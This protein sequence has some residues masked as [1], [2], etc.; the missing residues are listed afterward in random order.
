[1]RDRR[2]WRRASGARRTEA[3]LA[4]D[5]RGRIHRGSGDSNPF[6]RSARG[7]TQF[8]S[9]VPAK[10]GAALDIVFKSGAAYRIPLNYIEAWF[11][12]EPV[13]SEVLNSVASGRW[14]NAVEVRAVGASVSDHGLNVDLGLSDG[15]VLTLIWETVLMACEPRF[16]LFGGETEYSRALTHLYLERHGSLRLSASRD[17]G[18]PAADED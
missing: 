7:C 15:R 2:A 11:A 4:E 6:S 3:E 1:M 9:A 18:Q 17:L 13:Q 10:D 14:K 12:S 8:D 16:E 5:K